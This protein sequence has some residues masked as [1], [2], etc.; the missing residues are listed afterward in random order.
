MLSSLPSFYQ[1]N[2][3]DVYSHYFLTSSWSK[4][5]KAQ[6]KRA[7]KHTLTQ[8]QN[9]CIRVFVC[10]YGGVNICT[11]ACMHMDVCA[12]A[13]V[14]ASVSGSDGVNGTPTQTWVI[15]QVGVRACTRKR[16]S[17]RVEVCA[18]VYKRT[19]HQTLTR[20]QTQHKTD[21]DTKHKH[22]QTQSKTTK[23][24]RSDQ[25]LQRVDNGAS[26]QRACCWADHASAPS[27]TPC[28]MNIYKKSSIE[29]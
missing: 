6:E 12:C 9:M 4:Q 29:R 18:C 5:T 28:L 10:V 8:T 20:S 22:T 15:W 2:I 23:D 25:I 3:S 1:C 19:Y 16:E 11:R 7:Q 14:L 13:R 24:T 17:K 21:T 26:R 27:P